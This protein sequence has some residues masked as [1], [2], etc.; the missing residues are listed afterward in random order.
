VPDFLACIAQRPLGDP[1]N[2]TFEVRQ[3]FDERANP[4]LRK[5]SFSCGKPPVV[6]YVTKLAGI[7]SAPGQIE[8]RMAGNDATM[9]SDGP[10][11]CCA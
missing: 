10:V 11:W 6:T 2:A 4:G 8:S 1:S 9:I 7:R 3:V 5:P